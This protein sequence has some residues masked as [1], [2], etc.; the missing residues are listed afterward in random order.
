MKHKIRETMEIMNRVNRKIFSANERDE[1]TQMGRGQMNILR[2]IVNN[3]NI[4]QDEL[5][6]KLNLDKTTVAKAVKK[7]E[8]RGLII[9]KSSKEDKRK[10]EL[11]ATDEAK[12][13]KN[14]MK[15]HMDSISSLFFEGISEVEVDRFNSTLGKIEKN[16]ERNKN[17]MKNRKE[18]MMNVIKAVNRNENVDKAKLAKILDKDESSIEKIVQHLLEE[19]I[20]EDKDGYLYVTDKVKAHT[21]DKSKNPNNRHKE[22]RHDKKE[23]IKLLSK[24]NGLTLDEV[25]AKTSLPKKEVEEILNHLRQKNVLEIIDGKV[26]LDEEKLKK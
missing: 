3:E 9:R 2:V 23:F 15:E 14:K 4:T 19:G 8:L 26:Y 7:L 20:L 11:I 10:K 21:K 18:K 5:A 16:I 25:I 1:E 12:E 6:K 17:M 22:E 13:V 24:N